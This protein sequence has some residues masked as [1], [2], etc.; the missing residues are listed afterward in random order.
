SHRLEPS[1]GRGRPAGS[2]P[3]PEADFLRALEAAGG[4]LHKLEAHQVAREAGLD[5]TGLARLYKSDPPLLVTDG[6]Q[7]VMTGAGRDRLTSTPTA[8]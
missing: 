4:R 2:H 8:G 5:R 1:A 7:R 6:D 3:D